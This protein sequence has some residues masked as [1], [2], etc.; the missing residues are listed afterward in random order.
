MAHLRDVFAGLQAH[1]RHH[2]RVRLGEVLERCV[3]DRAERDAVHQHRAERLDG[4]RDLRDVAVVDAGNDDGVHLHQHAER[5]EP[6]DGIKLALDHESGSFLALERVVAIAHPAVNQRADRGIHGVDGDGDV[7]D[8]QRGDLI[9]VGA[10]VQAVAGEAEH[11]FR[12]AL[13][14]Q[15]QRFHRFEGIGERIARAGDAHHLDGGDFLHH[16]LE[17]G[18]GLHGR[19]HLAG[20]AGAAFIHA[21]ELAV[22]VVALDV[23]ARRD[24][25]VDAGELVTAAD[26]VARVAVE[27]EVFGMDAGA[28]R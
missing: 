22:A 8:F 19:E 16:F 25:Q 7:G 28:H 27:L 11:H 18:E 1:A 3:L 2:Q 10:D 23:A 24:G 6:G 9:D 15:P 14:H 12:E 21:V 17:V 13:P 20:D 5:G 4:A 26:A